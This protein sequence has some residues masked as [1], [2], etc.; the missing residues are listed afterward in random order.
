MKPILSSFQARAIT[1]VLKKV[2]G[3]DSTALID[4]IVTLIHREEAA[5][6]QR[7]YEIYEGSLHTSYANSLW[8]QN[9]SYSF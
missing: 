4:Y 6:G 9:Y 7:N 3:V 5:V 2:T 1:L 8:D